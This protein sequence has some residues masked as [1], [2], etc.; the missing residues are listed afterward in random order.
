[1]NKGFNLA[2]AEFD[3]ALRDLVNGSALPACSVRLVLERIL[4]EVKELEFQSIQKERREFQQEQ[5][6]RSPEQ[7]L[8]EEVDEE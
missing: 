7:T 2:V 3:T 8:F 1:M 6:G 4:Q 5:R